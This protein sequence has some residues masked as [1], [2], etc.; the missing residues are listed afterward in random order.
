MK[1]MVIPGKRWPLILSARD[2]M[3]TSHRSPICVWLMSKVDW[4]CEMQVLSISH[5]SVWRTV[6][7]NLCSA[8]DAMP[9][10]VNSDRCQCWWCLFHDSLQQVQGSW[11]VSYRSCCWLRAVLSLL[12][13][14]ALALVAF[15]CV[16][17]FAFV[18]ALA[19]VCLVLGV[20]CR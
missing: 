18:L 19:F 13:V 16:V 17:V 10:P 7:C 20:G 9:M 5:Q 3:S 1:R 8:R 6:T 12:F 2:V 4:K 14:L 15:V 11:V